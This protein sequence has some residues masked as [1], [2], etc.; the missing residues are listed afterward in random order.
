MPKGS[1]MSAE[2][3]PRL[4]VSRAA[5][6]SLVLGLLSPLLSLIA[7]VPAFLIGLRALRAINRSDGRLGGAGL[8]VA[9]MALGAVAGIVTAVGVLLIAVNRLQMTRDRVECADHLRA[10]GLAVRVYH[11][12]NDNV[13]PAATAAAPDLPADRRLSWLAVLLPYLGADTPSGRAWKDLGGRLDLRQPWDS[14]ANDADRVR[15]PLFLC[16]AFP[17]ASRPAER[18]LTSYVGVAGIDP[19]AA[20][21]SRNDPRAGFFGYGRTVTDTDLAAGASYILIAIETRRDNDPWAAGGRPSV[22][23]L[24]PDEDRYLGPGRPFGGLHA[25]GANALYADAAVHFLRDTMAPAE[26]RAEATLVG[27]ASEGAE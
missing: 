24:D 22:R 16:R 10:L 1:S 14:P 5:V 27:H 2:S 3:P 12:R 15:V 13:F 17:E 26:L 8:A 23:G 18:G 11:D 20:T 21:L 25:N 4:A 7:A 9:G 6:A 19:Q